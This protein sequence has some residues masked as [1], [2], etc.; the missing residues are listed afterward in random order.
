[1]AFMVVVIGYGV[2]AI[3][4]GQAVFGKVD[5]QGVEKL[6]RGDDAALGAVK[7]YSFT[8]CK[9]RFFASSRLA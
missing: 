8:L 5:L 3:I 9:L 2:A 7:K 6:L 1:M 4:R